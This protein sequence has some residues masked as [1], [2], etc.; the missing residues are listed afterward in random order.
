[1]HQGVYAVGHP[2]LRR[3]GHWMAASLACGPGAVVSHATAAA[4]WGI[5]DTAAATIDVTVP[6]RAGRCRPGLRIHGSRLEADERD[7]EDGIP[8]TSVARTLLDLAGVL[9]GRALEQVYERA[10]RRRV[11]DTRELELLIGR[12]HGGRGVWRLRSTLD[13]F[14]PAVL[15][16]RSE[17][18]VR[19]I[20]LCRDAA[21]PR[22]I[23][24]R[25]LRTAN[26]TFE[27]DF[28]WPSARLV[29]ETDGREFHAGA[30]ARR[31]DALR[32][33]ELK[34]AGWTVL[35]A[36]WGQVVV[37]PEPLILRLRRHLVR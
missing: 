3:E 30:R 23:V 9:R 28:H 10:E 18:E 35:R 29:V 32:D 2:A 31:A 37:T 22:P 27:V 5:R 24:N 17:L 19:F 8:C 14:D 12:H 11:L 20:R 26:S 34:A 15:D 6:S 1:M 7:I 16:A 36:T 33:R 4:L 25:L 21:L 13:G